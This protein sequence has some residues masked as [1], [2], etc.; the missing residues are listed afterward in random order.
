MIPQIGLS[1]FKIL[2]EVVGISLVER[3]N[4]LRSLA[5]FC[6]RMAREKINLIYLACG[7]QACGWG[8]DMAV[9]GSD[10]KKVTEIIQ[11]FFPKSFYRI[12][13]EG[14]LSLFPHRSD[15]AVAGNLFHALKTTGVVPTSLSYSN[16]AISVALQKET[17]DITTRALFQAF[18]FSAYRTPADWRLAQ[19]GKE[20]LYK[21]VVASYQETRPKVYGLHWQEAQNLFIMDMDQHV[22]DDVGDA[23]IRFSEKNVLLSFMVAGPS[24]NPSN[25]KLFLCLIPLGVT[26]P[27]H[28]L[29]EIFVPKAVTTKTAAVSVFV[30]NG[31]HFGD[32]YGIINEL[33]SAFEA[34]GVEFLAL[35]CAIASITGVV[36][37]DQIDT[38][39]N[40]IQS[41]FDVPAVIRKK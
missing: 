30:M 4:D 20:Q 18:Q 1:A 17:V 2:N 29:S 32:R 13:K 15:P 9:D 22:F 3:H 31:P 6:R 24:E 7:R 26:I 14:I 35:G 10:E 28:Q 41:N 8:L 36:P 23:L 19:H 34:F 11:E 12:A 38:A 33:L 25:F 39:T 21:E 40:A 16:S 5:E 27:S 37:S